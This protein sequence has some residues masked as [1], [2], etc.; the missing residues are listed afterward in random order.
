MILG[1]IAL[2]LAGFITFYPP[3]MT[4]EPNVFWLIMYAL[5]YIS[6]TM[7]ATFS[8]G[9]LIG[10]WFPRRK[11]TVM[12]IATLA[13]PVV[14]GIGLSLFGNMLTASGGKQLV[15][16]LPWLILDLIGILI[17][18]IFLKEYPEQCG[19]YPDNDKN[20]TPEQ[21][22]QM[23]DILRKTFAAAFADADSDGI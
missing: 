10:Q 1:A 4:Q 15:G 7:Y 19:A 2:I 22:Q 23:M 9:V 13:F 18:V 17:C 5:E 8:I 16:W 20:M 21:Q 11:G 3:T 14:N 12:G 6:V